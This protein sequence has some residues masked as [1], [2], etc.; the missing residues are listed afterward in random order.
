MQKIPYKGLVKLVIRQITYITGN[1]SIT[2]TTLPN[3]IH[4]NRA[5]V[6]VRSMDLENAETDLASMS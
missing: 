6:D 5:S 3:Q 4:L 2:S 1:I